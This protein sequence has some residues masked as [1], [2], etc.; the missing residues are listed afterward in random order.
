MVAAAPQDRAQNAPT[1]SDYRPLCC[2]PLQILLPLPARGEAVHHGAMGEGALGGRDVF[3]PAG[4][5]LLRRGLQRAAVAEGDA[6]RQ[7][8]DAVNGVEVGGCLLV[9]LAAG[10]ERDAGDGGGTQALGSFTVFS[11]TSST[12]ARFFDFLPAT[13]MLGLS[14]IP[15]SAT[16]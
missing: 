14:T 16:L 2:F 11:A 9:R 10:E 15:S 4:P 1:G 7:A 5:G 13:T 3:A 8:A 6:P 12:P